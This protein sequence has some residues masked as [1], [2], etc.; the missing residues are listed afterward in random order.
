MPAIWPPVSPGDAP[1]FPTAPPV[2][3]VV[4]ED[5]ALP[6]PVIVT[7][8][9]ADVATTGS[10]TPLHL[11]SVSENTQHESVAFGELAAQ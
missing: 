9:N 4:A 7:G 6:V 11:V 1:W 2:A 5:V 3:L 8:L 10:L